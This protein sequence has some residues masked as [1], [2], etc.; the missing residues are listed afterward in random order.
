MAAD[1]MVWLG[2]ESHVDL[3]D[4]DAYVSKAVDVT[5]EFLRAG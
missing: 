3:Y 1:R 5:A 2:C 4:V